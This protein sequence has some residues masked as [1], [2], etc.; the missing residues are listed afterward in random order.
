MQII[1]QI[2]Q[3]TENEINKWAF[4][5]DHP[6]MMKAFCRS[7]LPAETSPLEAS[8][9]PHLESQSVKLPSP[10]SP[11][12]PGWLKTFSEDGALETKASWT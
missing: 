5:A 2:R 6:E 9:G 12:G 3:G 4:L 7:S 11:T 10:C 8:R 1:V